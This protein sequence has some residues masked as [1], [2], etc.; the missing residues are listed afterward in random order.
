MRADV[1]YG[2]CPAC[3]QQGL[4]LRHQDGVGLCRSC[5]DDLEG[6]SKRP[7]RAPE[8]VFWLVLALLLWVALWV[9]ALASFGW[10]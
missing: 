7:V 5:L 10:W 9:R 8:K 3:A 1:W 4:L 6:P 2:T